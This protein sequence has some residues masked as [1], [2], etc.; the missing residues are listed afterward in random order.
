MC[1]W[2]KDLYQRMR[3]NADEYGALEKDF[4]KIYKSYLRKWSGFAQD[5]IP[6]LPIELFAFLAHRDKHFAVLSFLRFRQVIRLMRVS[7]FFDRWEQEL[8]INILKVRLTKFFVLLLIII[9]LF[10][11]IWYTIACPLGVCKEG[12]W[13]TK[14]GYRGNEP[15]IFYRYCDTIYWA[16]ATLT[17]T[18]YGDIHVYSVPEL[19]FASMV[20]VFGKLLFGWVLGNIASTL[21]NEESGRVSYEERL[22]AVKD[23]MKDMRLNSKLRN[24]VIS[25]FDYLWARNKGIDQSILFRDAPFCLQTDLGLDVAGEHLQ[26]VALFREADEAFLRA[27]S[28][29]L[30]PVLFMPNDLIVRQGDVG[31]EMYFICRGVVEE[32]EVN[33]HSRVARV[34]ESGEF[35]D[36]INL[37]YDVP[38]R[39]SYRGRTHVDVLSLSV[40]DLKSVLEQYPQVEAQIRRIGKELYYGAPSVRQ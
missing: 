29:M 24:R 11:S 15:Y 31:D 7:Q 25:Y 23:Q 18:G 5:L 12:S 3:I 8:N 37:L 2:I 13:A 16:V 40:H 27:L 32:L 39:T 14:M 21:A 17:S 34:L 30:K 10:A 38:R 28:L 20:M 6:T 1:G 36:D 33:S 26:K 9:H 19:I 35:L 4:S 22:A